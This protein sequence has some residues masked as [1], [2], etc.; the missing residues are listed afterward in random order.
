MSVKILSHV[1]TLYILLTKYL[2]FNQKKSI[3]IFPFIMIAY[4]ITDKKYVDA[5]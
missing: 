1:F 4:Y 3:A 2:H 5:L